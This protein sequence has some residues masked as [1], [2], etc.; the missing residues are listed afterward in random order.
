MSSGVI[1]KA[2]NVLLAVILAV[3]M[4]IGAASAAFPVFSDDR[5]FSGV[6][7][8]VLTDPKINETLIEAVKKS[9]STAINKALIALTDPNWRDAS[10]KSAY[11]SAEQ[12]GSDLSLMKIIQE[13]S[14]YI[15]TSD[16]SAS[17]PILPPDS[18]SAPG[19]LRQ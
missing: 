1:M 15:P 12:V 2:C 16:F 10:S 5:P 6:R 7:A 13:V 9:D 14:I 11:G 19:C 3:C 4:A 18:C 17:V 8:A